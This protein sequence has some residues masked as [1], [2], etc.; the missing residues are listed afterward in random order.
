MI[1]TNDT[2]SH[3]CSHATYADTYSHATYADTY[4]HAT[5]SHSCSHDTYA[6]TCSHDTYAH[7]CSHDTYSHTCSHDTY[8]HT[9]SH[10]T[11]AHT[12]SHD[13]YSQ[14][15]RKGNAS[16]LPHDSDL[17]H[18]NTPLTRIYDSDRNVCR[19]PADN[20]VLTRYTLLGDRKGNASE[21]VTQQVCF[22]VYV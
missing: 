7:T 10:D 22:R 16:R 19:H 14:G 13:T 2:Y 4:S 3:T 15:D 8:S 6:H 1:F 11:Y 20:K 18:A 9:Y 5:Y 21:N 12:C 17:I